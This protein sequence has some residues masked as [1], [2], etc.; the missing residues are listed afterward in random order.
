MKR[1][2]NKTDIKKGQEVPRINLN[3]QIEVAQYLIQQDHS[4]EGG[5]GEGKRNKFKDLKE[6]YKINKEHLIEIKQ[7]LRS[8][9]NA[10]D[11]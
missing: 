7:P 11:P 10:E 6:T 9:A 5:G 1:P 8:H 4:K 3:M 2:S